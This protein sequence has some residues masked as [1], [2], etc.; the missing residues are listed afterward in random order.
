MMR[1]IDCDFQPIRQGD[2]VYFDGYYTVKMDDEGAYYLASHH[3]HTAQTP[4]N[5]DVSLNAD[6]ARLIKVLRGDERSER[7]YQFH[8]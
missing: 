2:V 6:N 8:S 5:E 7:H 1:F 4:F 3:V